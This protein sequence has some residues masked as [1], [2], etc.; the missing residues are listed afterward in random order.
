MKTIDIKI[1]A[2]WEKK[3]EIYWVLTAFILGLVIGGTI[4]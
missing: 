1:E 3:I 2:L 4:L